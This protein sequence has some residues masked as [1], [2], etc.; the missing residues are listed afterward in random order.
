MTC[1]LDSHIPDS[2]QWQLF[3]KKTVD[4]SSATVLAQHIVNHIMLAEW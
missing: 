4:Q 1:V 3:G 2:S